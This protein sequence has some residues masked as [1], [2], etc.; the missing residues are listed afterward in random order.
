MIFLILWLAGYFLRLSSDASPSIRPHR[1]LYVAVP[2]IRN[3]LEYGGHGLLVYDID[4]EHRLVRRIPTRGLLPD[5]RPD[6]VKGIDASL[7]HQ[8]IYITTIHSIQ[9]ISLRTDS[10]RWEIALPKGCDRLSI[11]QDGHHIFLPSF[12]KDLWYIMEAEHGKLLDSVR[13]D[14]KAHNTISS[15]DGT[16]VYLQG[17]SSRYI[18]VMD[19]KNYQIKRKIGPFSNI[20]RPFTVN[21]NQTRLYT[22]V[23]DLLGFEAADLTTG[24]VL[25]SVTV[26]QYQKGP[27]KRHGC[28]SHGIALNPEESEIWIADAFNQ[29]LHVFP[30]AHDAKPNQSTAISLRDQPGWISFSK[31]GQYAYPSTGEVIDARTKQIV[32]SLQDEKGEPVHSEKMMEISFLRGQAVDM[33]D[34][35]AMGRK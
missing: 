11:S 27:I 17:L 4:Q 13:P 20:A 10:I 30:L 15:P 7:A 9:C 33:A 5:G 31:N 6:N 19:A 32:Y 28:P 12:E 14:I 18:L 21:G 16:E 35:F 29:K 25:Y 34:Q 23:N 22:N 24:E 26:D 1:Y 3:Y 8:S 2:G